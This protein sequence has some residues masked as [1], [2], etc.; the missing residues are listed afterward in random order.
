M[1]LLLLILIVPLLWSCTSG[2]VIRET[3][4][5]D[6]KTGQIIG[7]TTIFLG[8]TLAAKRKGVVTQVKK[9]GKGGW[10]VAY[11]VDSESS[12]SVPMAGMAAWASAAM[13]SDA[14]SVSTAKEATTRHAAS[15]ATAQHAATTAGQTAVTTEAIKAGTPVTVAPI[16]PP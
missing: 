16:T 15:Q 9:T 8:G 3:G 14:A 1:K 6:Q 2:P 7:S 12:E 4:T 5:L 11:M 10:S 13:S